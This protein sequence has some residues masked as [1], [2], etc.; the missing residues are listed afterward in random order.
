MIPRDVRAQLDCVTDSRMLLEAN[1]LAQARE[2][3]KAAVR[4]N[5]KFVQDP[6]VRSVINC[7]VGDYK[8]RE[9]SIRSFKRT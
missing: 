3:V 9:S 5:P 6:I 8:V 1:D 4:L 2:H 7:F